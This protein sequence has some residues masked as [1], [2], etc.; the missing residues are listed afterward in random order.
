MPEISKITLPSG[1]SYDIKDATA[2]TAIENLQNTENVLSTNAATTPSGVTWN[3]N[4]NTI[5]GTLAASSGTIKKIYLVPVAND[6]TKNNYREYLTVKNGAA[7][8]WEMIGTTETSLSGLGALAYKDSATGQYT[9]E[10]SVSQPTFSGS[11]LTSTGSYT[12]SGSVAAPVISVSVAGSTDSVYSITNLGTL[13]SFSATV[14][15]EVLTL[16]YT[17]GALPSRT[18]KTVKTGDPTYAA[19]SPAFSGTAATVTV[20]G[21]PSGTVSQPSF[22]GTQKTVSVS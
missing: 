3:S 10:G 22:S 17:V 16:S 18:S 19:T 15:D 1:V 12:P 14:N 20:K 9:P 2:R 13:P 21:T 6:D 11:E 4:G 5:T 7:Y 8:S